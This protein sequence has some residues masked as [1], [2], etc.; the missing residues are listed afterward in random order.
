MTNIR[1]EEPKLDM[2]PMIDCVFQLLIFFV[3]TLKPEDILAHLDVNRPM[4]SDDPTEERLIAM[5]VGIYPDGVT[6]DG[7]AMS[8]HSLEVMLKRLAGLSRTQTVLI[9]CAPDSSHERLVHVL[10]LCSRVGLSNLSVMSL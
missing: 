4:P 8:L 1:G 7:R 3:L 10:D 2:T 5:E 9:K 6:L